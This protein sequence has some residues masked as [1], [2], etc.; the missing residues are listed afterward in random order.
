MLNFL[1][2]LMNLENE[3]YCFREKQM[4]ELNHEVQKERNIRNSFTIL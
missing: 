4:Y 1:K 2:K 3:F